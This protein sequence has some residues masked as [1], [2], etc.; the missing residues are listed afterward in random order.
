MDN[1]GRTFI[2]NFFPTDF[3]KAHPDIELHGDGVATLLKAKKE[4]RPVLL[5]SG[6][7]GNH[8]AMRSALFQRGFCIG[9]MIR[10][11]RNPLVNKIYITAVDTAGR[12]GQA[13][14]STRQG[15]LGFRK[16]LTERRAF[17]DCH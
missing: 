10:D 4:G 9:G 11:M 5:I 6:H 3:H 2:E 1:A 7:F 8:E 17:G 13:F 12:G 14:K 15:I 16:A